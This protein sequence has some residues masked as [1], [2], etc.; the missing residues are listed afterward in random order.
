MEPIFTGA[1]SREAIIS[2]IVIRIS[3]RSVS[4]VELSRP[5]MAKT[6]TAES[7]NRRNTPALQI[8]VSYVPF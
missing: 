7:I 2:S 4:L 8:N 1:D 6:K 5:I 3:L